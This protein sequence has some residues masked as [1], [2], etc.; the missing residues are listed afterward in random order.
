M[1]SEQHSSSSCHPAISLRVHHDR[2]SWQPRIRKANGACH[3]PP[4][5]PS[6][7]V[8]FRKVLSWALCKPPS[9]RNK[10]KGHP[11]GHHISKG[12]HQSRSK[13]R[14]LPRRGCRNPKELGCVRNP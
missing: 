8:E 7:V 2:Y 9:A 11:K 1:Q 12:K 14:R 5:T 6:K 3:L 4:A 13:E 10:L